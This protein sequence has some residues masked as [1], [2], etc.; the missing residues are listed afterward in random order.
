[1]RGGG[2]VYHSFCPQEGMCG[3]GVTCVAKGSMHGKKGGVHGR[4]HAWW[5]A[6]VAWDMHGGGMHGRGHVWWGYAWQERWP[7]QQ[8]VC[9]LLEYTLD[10]LV[11]QFIGRSR[12]RGGTKY[13]GWFNFL[14]FHAVFGINIAQ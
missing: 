6:C 4:G 5:G 3:K 9:I 12:V 11:G 7:L 1:M 13:A 14:H 8:M 2:D 10:F